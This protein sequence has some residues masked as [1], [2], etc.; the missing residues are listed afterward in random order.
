M[1][2]GER[3][4]LEGGCRGYSGSSFLGC[5]NLGHHRVNVRNK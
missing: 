2:E 5:K 3:G 4:D 1:N